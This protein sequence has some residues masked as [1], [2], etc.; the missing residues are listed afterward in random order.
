MYMAFAQ[1]DAGIIVDTTSNTSDGTVTSLTALRASKGADG[2]ISLREAIAAANASRNGANIDEIKFA[3]SGSGVQTISVTGTDLAAFTEAIYLNGTSQSGYSGSPLISIVDGDTRATGLTLSSGSDGSTIRGL[4]IQ[5]FGTSGIAITSSNN[6]IAGNWIGTNATGSAAA[7]NYDG[8]AIWQGDNNIIG[9]TSTLDRNV[10][11]GQT[12]NA[13]SISGNGDNTQILG[14]YIGTNKDGTALVANSV[15]GVWI[16]DSTG[17]IIG[18]NT[19]SRRNVIVG[20]GYGIG[21]SN[22]DN[23]TVQG[24]YIGVAA[25]GSTIL[26]ND[27]AGIYLGNGSSGALIGTNADGTN[28]SA[29]GNV[30]SGSGNGIILNGT[31]TSG[32]TIY[33]N[34][35]GTDATGLLARGNTYDGIR[36]ENGATGNYVGGSGSARRNIIAGNGQ[37]GVQVDGEASDGNFIQNNYIGLASDGVTVIGNGGDGIYISG[38]ADN[39]TIGG[40]GLGNIILGSRVVGIEIDGAS[41][42]TTIYGNYIGINIA[43]PSSKVLARMAFFL[44]TALPAPPSVAPRLDRVTP[45]SIVV[46]SVTIIKREF[47]SPLPPERVTRSSATRST[48]I[49]ATE[50][51]L[52]MKVPIATI[53][54]IP[55]QEPTTFRIIQASV[56]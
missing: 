35:I 15:S 6:T 3:I 1:K 4:N 11:S 24:N 37:D 52:V 46:D 56:V 40:V 50:S 41:S 49:V 45:L 42:G 18:G 22:A 8:I 53:R 2:K 29:E 23:L 34:L 55:I 13:I 43:G 9:G 16:G 28:D 21:G 26:G 19:S 27:W 44:K 20:D 10:L 31:G 12:N 48:T 38:G 39:T 17:T 5:G 7:A 25:D 14:N 30:L 51:T 32:A 36:I 54:W 47:R 33:G